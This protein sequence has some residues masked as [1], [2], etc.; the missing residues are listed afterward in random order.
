MSDLLR[1]T[2]RD[3]PDLLDRATG[4]GDGSWSDAYTAID[5][6]AFAF[7][8]AYPTHPCRNGCATCCR[9][10]LFR[11]TRAEWEPMQAALLADPRL[12]DLLARVIRDFGPHRAALEEAADRWSRPDPAETTSVGSAPVGPAPVGPAPVGPT[13]GLAGVPVTCPLLEGDS[14]MAYDTR[15]AICRAYGSF[16]ARVGEKDTFL[17]CREHGPDFVRGLADSGV[18]HMLM[19][20]WSPVQDRLARLNPSGEVAPLPLWLLRL[21]LSGPASASPQA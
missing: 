16:G 10:Q 21:A 5:Y 13:P 12:E 9:S 7:S 11:V 6:M 2:I 20:P 1:Q 19:P 18:E 17:M 8:R 4:L 14:C 3:L 15:P